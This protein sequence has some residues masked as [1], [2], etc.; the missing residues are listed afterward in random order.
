[1]TFWEERHGNHLCFPRY[2]AVHDENKSPCIYIYAVCTIYVYTAKHIGTGFSSNNSHR[3]GTD[4]CA[5]AQDDVHR[6][7][8]NGYRVGARWFF[9]FFFSYVSCYVVIIKEPRLIIIISPSPPRTCT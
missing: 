6:A 7:R 9:D 5:S 8:D 1:M 4:T 2:S 3:W